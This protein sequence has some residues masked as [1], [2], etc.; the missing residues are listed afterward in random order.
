MDDSNCGGIYFDGGVCIMEEEIIMIDKFEVFYK[1]Y[2]WWKARGGMH[3]YGWGDGEYILE[4][5]KNDPVK[6]IKLGRLQGWW[7]E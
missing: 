4:G 7:E 6:V 5:L 2:R 1:W 3:Y